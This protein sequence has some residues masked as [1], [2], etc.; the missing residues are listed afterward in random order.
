MKFKF[1][2]LLALL[3]CTAFTGHVSAQ[4][5]ELYHNISV[6]VNGGAAF[7][8]MFFQPSIKQNMMIGATGGVTFRY[9]SEKYFAMICGVQLE[10]NYTQKGWEERFEDS[11][12]NE[13]T[14][15]GYQHKMDY[16]EIPFLAHL[17]FGKR[18]Q[19]FLNLGPQIG[20]LI[21]DKET[22]S[23]KL[24]EN[25]KLQHSQEEYHKRIDN[26]FD[27]GITAGGGLEIRT[28]KAGNFLIEGRYYYALSD[29]FHNTKRD[30]FGRS[31]HGTIV[32]KV[33]YLFDITK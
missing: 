7:N 4:V 28:R 21:N 5:G 25:S 6:G 19:F 1:K 22:F 9:I 3:A 17:A 14:S 15:L 30:Y 10:V 32:A 33:T 18:T 16:L 27:Y 2:Y 11:N 20:F 31:A 8:T 29:I 23:G 12:G 13:D 26:K 24:A